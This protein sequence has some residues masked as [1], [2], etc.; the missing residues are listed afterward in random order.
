MATLIATGLF[1]AVTSSQ[2][3]VESLS[4]VQSDARFLIESIAQSVRLAGLDYSY[5]LNL[6]GD[7]NT[8]DPVDLS[9]GLLSMSAVTTD[10]AQVVTKDASGQTFFSRYMRGKFGEEDRYAIGVCTRTPAQFA[11]DPLRC[12]YPTLAPEDY[13][14]VTP[15][16]ITVDAFNVWVSPGSDPN[17]L[18]PSG[19][20]DCWTNI[21][22]DPTQVPPVFGFDSINS[23]CTCTDASTDC[24]SGQ[25]CDRGICLNTNQQPKVTIVISSRGGGSR[26]AE[27]A[28]QTLQTTVS[29]RI[30]KR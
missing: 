19:T 16:N 30:Y 20:A 21:N 4:K 29:A 15:T 6:D 1:V 9:G 10:T 28:T 12:A 7:P 27:Q 14:D 13:Q 18:A 22:A 23:N 24:W 5:Y 25:T 2:K 11:S 3:K 17:A 26:Q 8:R